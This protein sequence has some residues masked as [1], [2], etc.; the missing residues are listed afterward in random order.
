MARDRRKPRMADHV[1][2][3]GRADVLSDPLDDLTAQAREDFRILAAA[4]R[5]QD[6]RRAQRSKPARPAR[7]SL[8]LV[9]K[10]SA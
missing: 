4:I 6:Q 10:E 5:R 2:F 3:L 1:I 7:A 9:K 8:R